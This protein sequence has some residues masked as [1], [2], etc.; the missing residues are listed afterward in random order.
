M[1]DSRASPRPGDPPAHPPS[2]GPAVSPAVQ[3]GPDP[4]SPGRILV[5]GDWHGNEDWALH[6][7]NRVPRVL[8]GETTRMIL[9]LGDFG[10]WP[11][12]AGAGRATR[13]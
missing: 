2:L 3:P 6:V 1:T 5:A 13:T 11:D 12:R 9:H 10:I 4:V 8:A 7:I